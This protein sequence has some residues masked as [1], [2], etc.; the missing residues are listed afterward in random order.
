M[1]RLPVPGQDDGTWGNILNDFLS[2]E[3]NSDGTLKTSGT[4]EA[5]VGKGD[6]VINVKDYGATGDGSTDD[7]AAIAGAVAALTS[8]STLYFP[9]GTYVTSQVLLSGKSNFKITGAGATI[10]GSN[11][12][13]A[14]LRLSTCTF[15]EV[16]GLNVHHANASVRNS[17]GHGM[18]LSNCTDYLVAHNTVYGTAAAGII[19]FTGSRGTVSAN[20]VHDT[21]ADGIH[22]TK[23]SSSITVTG[24][25]LVNTG[26]DSLAVVSYLADGAICTD[27]SLTGNTVYQ[28]NARG[29]A[30]VGGENVT[31]S[32]NTVRTTKSAGIYVSQE[33]SWNTYGVNTV[34]VVGNTVKDANTY[35]PAFAAA[36][37][38]VSGFDSSNIVQGVH[39]ASN[40][41]TGGNAWMIY[42]VAQAQAQ[43]TR[44]TISANLCNGPN[45]ASPGIRL[46][47]VT[48]SVVN[49]NT[50]RYAFTNGIDVDAS[51][52]RV[53]VNHNVVFYPNQSNAGTS[54][55]VVNM[56]TAGS[57]SL[58]V[59]TADA[60][61][62]ALLA[63]VTSA[64]TTGT[65]QVR[66][67]IQGVQFISSAT[68]RN[69]IATGTAGLFVA[70]NDGG[71]AWVS[72]T[73]A[74]G[75]TMDVGLARD[76][77]G[78][79]KITNGSTGTG[80]LKGYQPAPPMPPSGWYF[81]PVSQAAAST[82]ATLGNG[83]LR[84]VPFYLPQ[85]TSI[86]RIGSE[87]SVVGQAGSLLR[88]GV[89]S[90]NL[91]LPGSLLLDAGTIAGDSATVQEITLGSPLAL[92]AGWYWVGG[93]VQ[94]AASTQ[95]TVR[96]T[97][98]VTTPI[99]LGALQSMPGS[100][101][102]TSGYSA[103]G[104]TGALPGTFTAWAGGPSAITSAPRVF[105]RIT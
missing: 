99:L 6:L 53:D 34:A 54:Y 17:T 103:S 28:A 82:N 52:T 23:G 47:A 24:N 16:S 29:I 11:T 15:F 80:L 27:I 44:L 51:S 19:S 60:G 42:A 104:V 78:V 61:K 89:Y 68:N 95:P 48:D 40:I 91:G 86:S 31:I 74:G 105:M 35:S 36:S 79:V 55:G 5:Y 10:R 97:S 90:D 77:A 4:L 67:N 22:H 69:F 71:V 14:V 7:T 9:G 94:N 32:G 3:H 12:A 50:V 59:V 76:A 8:G 43:I 56:A 57:S 25:N 98:G 37:I 100:S 101:A 66:K 64:D 83:T 1:T 75:G 70:R 13:N 96:V 65:V 73:N 63:E 2:V 21:L 38:H 87:I 45:V 39:I 58:N 72:D 33:S 102:T 49:G 92:G 93:A 46:T 26:D 20:S 30:V 81:F 84:L 18:H 88:L 41:I 85:A 62:T